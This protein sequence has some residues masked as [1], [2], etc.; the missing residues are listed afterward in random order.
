MDDTGTRDYLTLEPLQTRIQM[1]QR[2]SELPDDPEAAA[3]VPL[4]DIVR[5]VAAVDVGCGTGSFLRQVRASGHD[6][7]LI[8]VDTSEAALV[9]TRKAGIDAVLQG[10]ACRP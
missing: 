6:G 3:L 2:Y 10:D 1:H 8:G 9:S 5:G 7:P 4:E